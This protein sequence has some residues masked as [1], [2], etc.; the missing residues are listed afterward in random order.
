M[1]FVFF[2][3]ASLPGHPITPLCT[4]RRCTQA[5]S[6]S[7]N[8]IL[9][10]SAPGFPHGD[11][12]ELRNECDMYMV[13]L[14]VELEELVSFLGRADLV[15]R[16]IAICVAGALIEATDSLIKDT[17]LPF[18]ALLVPKSLQERKFWVLRDGT[19]GGAYETADEAIK[20]GALVVQ[21]GKSIRTCIVF[22]IQ[23][24]IVF[25]VIRLMSKTKHL[26]GAAGALGSRID[27]ALPTSRA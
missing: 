4:F 26:P 25:L 21:F 19:S 23:G 13:N 17:L 16:V 3:P 12:R 6:S 22:L 8:Q 15:D 5:T 18:V 9:V 27:A 24:L 14:R 11:A 10:A 7:R 2:I 20:D 1:S